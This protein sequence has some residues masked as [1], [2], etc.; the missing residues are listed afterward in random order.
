MK[1]IQ[2]LLA[3]IT[4]ASLP[5]RAADKLERGEMAGYLLVPHAKVPE[6]FN[7][8]FSLYAAAWPVL[9]SPPSQ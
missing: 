6:T 7:A 9:D 4:L 1:P 8:G 3:I 5:A 2:L